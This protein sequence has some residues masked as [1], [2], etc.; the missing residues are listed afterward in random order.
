MH[1][2]VQSRKK[3]CSTIL[4]ALVKCSGEFLNP[5]FLKSLALLEANR[6]MW[7]ASDHRL[8]LCPF[9]GNSDR[10]SILRERSNE[11]LNRRT[12]RFSVSQDIASTA[13]RDE[14]TSSWLMSVLFKRQCFG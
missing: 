2:R 3:L 1:S 12:K 14:F 5:I 13:G 8:S 7:Y 11:D 4:D 6:G 10:S 9:R